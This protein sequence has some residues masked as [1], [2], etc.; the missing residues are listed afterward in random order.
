MP[1][2][3]WGKYVPPETVSE[4][5]KYKVLYEKQLIA[6]EKLKE[7]MRHALTC[8]HASKAPQELWEAWID[9]IHEQFSH[10]LGEI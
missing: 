1:R 6:N 2:S 3:D 7:L 9:N 5:E 10:A 8:Y 4:T